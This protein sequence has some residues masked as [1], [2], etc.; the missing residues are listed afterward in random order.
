MVIAKLRVEHPTI[1]LTPT[2]RDAP[3]TD[4]YPE[5][6]PASTADSALLFVT[7]EHDVERLDSALAADET[8][9]GSRLV[10]DLGT[11]RVYRVE[12]SDRATVFTRELANLAIQILEFQSDDGGWLLRLQLPDR[13]A[14]VA[15]CE[16]CDAEAIHCELETLYEDDR[17]GGL[18]GYGLT[19]PQRDAI[20][21]AYHQGYFNDPREV[22]LEDLATEMGISAAA[23][24]RRLRRA[25]DALVTQTLLR[26]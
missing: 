15:F 5:F 21:A 25:T 26:D 17:R 2:S 14:L 8:I 23:L 3:R 18:G 11:R 22:T 1:P 10:T 19:D 20:I 9:A 16:Y 4:F 6:Q 12:L 24:G 7:M 13:D